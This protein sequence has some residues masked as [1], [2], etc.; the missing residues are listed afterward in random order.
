MSELTVPPPSWITLLR[1]N[2]TP[3]LQPLIPGSTPV[4]WYVEV[5]FE[6]W[7]APFGAPK[8][9]WSI[10]YGKTQVLDDDGGRSVAEIEL[11]R[12]MRGGGWNAGW[13]DS[14]GSAPDAWRQW[15]VDPGEL[16]TP[17]R[18]SYNAITNDTGVSG[19]GGRPDI[20]AWNGDSLAGAVFI[21]YKGP[22]DRIR[23][24]QDA[25]L[26]A[27]LRAGIT[28]DQFVVAKWRGNR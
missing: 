26:E 17:L 9:P 23:P 18:R 19:K 27:A 5:H 4:A 28:P 2:T 16:P 10:T 7:Q 13:V 14:F 8:L 1:P 22:K 25:W 6:P 24:G 12:R 11:V 20:I 3:V 15:L 21:E